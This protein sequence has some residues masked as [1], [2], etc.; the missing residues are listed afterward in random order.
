MVSD[1]NNLLIDAN[2]WIA[3]VDKSESHFR[4]ARKIIR[5]AI[6]KAKWIFLTDFIIQEVLTVLLY[7]EKQ[8]LAETFLEFINDEPQ[9][10]IIGIDTLLLQESAYFA[11][12]KKYKPKISFTDWSLLYVADN[13]V[14]DLVTF[15]KQ[16]QN[17]L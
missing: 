7:K 3:Y 10:S 1:G 4:E 17:T 14:V 16:L 11:Q 6:K 5:D 8:H 12:Q 9:V 2:V 15:D 13:C